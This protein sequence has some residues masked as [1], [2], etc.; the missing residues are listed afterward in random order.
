MR[1]VSRLEYVGYA[2]SPRGVARLIGRVNQCP[3]RV[4]TMEP[5]YG[6]YRRTCDAGTI[7]ILSVSAAMVFQFLWSIRVEAVYQPRGHDNTIIE[8]YRPLGHRVYQM[9]ARAIFPAWLKL[10]MPSEGKDHEP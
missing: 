1:A 9:H 8:M 6:E 2:L 3:V 10:R 7:L 5:F 4:V